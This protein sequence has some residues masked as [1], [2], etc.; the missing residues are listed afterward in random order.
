MVGYSG[1]FS[2]LAHNVS[3]L[4]TIV[5]DC[6]IKLSNFDYD[7]SGPAVYV[8][9]GKHHDYA[10]VEAF[11]ISQRIEG[12]T[13]QDAEFIFRLPTN[14]TLDDL[15]GL[16]VWCDDFNADFGHMTFTP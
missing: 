9:A 15:N 14:K 11:S 16:S 3:G 4:A 1:F 10:S 7:G 12:Q 8:Y 5:D 13:N 2:T 6:T